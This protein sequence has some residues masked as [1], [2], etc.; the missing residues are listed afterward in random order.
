[1]I[2]FTFKNFFGDAFDPASHEPTSDVLA[3][4]KYPVEIEA[5]E[6]SETKAGNGHYIK[7]TMCILDG[8]GKNRK[9]WDYINI[10]N[11]SAECVKIGMRQ[12]SALCQAVGL[13]ALRDTD[14]L[15]GKTC[16]AHVKVKDDQNSVR[17][18]SSSS[19]AQPVQQSVQQPGSAY[20]PAQTPAPVPQAG[21][22]KTPWGGNQT[23]DNGIPF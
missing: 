21:P 4:G 10:D 20:Q 5:A 9:V 11:P 2:D 3:P 15:L 14:E 6:I 19:A 1:M 18:Y 22:M 23:K 17:T 16:L 7:V 8:P 13:I 12:L